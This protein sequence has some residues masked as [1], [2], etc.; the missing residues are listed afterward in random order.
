MIKV[1]LPTRMSEPVPDMIN[2]SFLI[3]GEKKGGKTST[4]HQAGDVL[5]L[6]HDP[7]QKALKRWESYCPDWPTFMSLLKQ[8][9]RA[10]EKGKCRFDHVCVDGVD[11]WYQHCLQYV[12]A[13]RGVDYP[14]TT[15]F[16]KDWKAVRTEF[17]S[18]VV[19]LLALPL[20]RWFICHSKFKEI[21]QR[22]GAKV[23]RLLPNMSGQAE[24][25]LNG[26]VDAWFAYDRVGITGSRVLILE[27]DEVTGAG[28]RIDTEDDPH[29]RCSRTGKKLTQIGMGS[30]PREGYANLVAAFDNE[31]ESDRPK[32]KKKRK[33]RG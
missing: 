27:G 14:S 23:D 2:Y 19:R 31:Y 10:I 29:F 26:M 17:D 11:R 21:K 30:S 9:E 28:H 4:V 22:D 12:C 18:A 24:E 13:K 1:R 7:P 6:Q 8:L 5:F 33:V 32:K 15:D 3:H 25:T 20:G 16:G